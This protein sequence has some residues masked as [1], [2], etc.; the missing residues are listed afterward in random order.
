MRNTQAQ[1][2]I[3]ELLKEA[4]AE[5]ESVR[6]VAR[7]TGVA[8]PCLVRF[9][10]GKQSLHLDNADKLAEHFGFKVTRPKRRAKKGR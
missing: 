6:A 5:V 2:T 9:L 8:Q 3:A 7:A 1:P 4:L 10:S